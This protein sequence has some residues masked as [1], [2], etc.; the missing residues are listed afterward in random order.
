MGAVFS[1]PCCTQRHKEAPED[2][3]NH[4]QL[5]MMQ[6]RLSATTESTSGTDDRRGSACSAAEV[7]EAAVPRSSR[8][9]S[10]GQATEFPPPVTP[11]Q[12]S[13]RT[14]DEAAVVPKQSLP[15]TS[16]VPSAEAATAIS[17]SGAETSPK[18]GQEVGTLPE[19]TE[20]GDREAG[21]QPSATYR[22]L[23]HWFESPEGNNENRNSTAVKDEEAPATR[24]LR[25][26]T[27]WYSGSGALAGGEAGE[28]ASLAPPPPTSTIRE[29][30]PA[31][32]PC[33]YF[34]VA[35]FKAEAADLDTGSFLMVKGSQK[36]SQAP[37]PA[38]L[39]PTRTILAN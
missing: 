24:I 26:L 25:S 3:E 2:E 20:V 10:A 18:N 33:H 14:N 32:A 37:Q 27:N 1:S 13:P 31:P 5:N 19:A 9:S 28:G 21:T 35:S 12:Q 4:A 6:Q 8:G 16:R 39:P 29:E 17:T 38:N 34:D 22:S 30:T 36:G 7:P 23:T 11:T 15:P